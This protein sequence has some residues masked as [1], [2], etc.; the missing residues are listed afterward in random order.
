S[1]PVRFEEFRTTAVHRTDDPDVLVLEY[2]LGGTVL[3]T[4]KQAAAP[5]IVVV[6]VRDG[7]VVGWR[8]YQDTLAIDDALLTG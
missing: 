5:F 1:L 6:R 7:L 3:T 8:E 4:G 2:V